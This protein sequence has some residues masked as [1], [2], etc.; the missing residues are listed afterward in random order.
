[1]TQ[2]DLFNIALAQSA[3]DLSCT[4][5]DLVSEILSAAV[6][7]SQPLGRPILGT[8]G[9]LQ[10]IDSQALS[11]YCRKQ[12]VGKNTIISLCGSFSEADLKA[13]E[14]IYTTA[15]KPGEDIVNM[16]DVMKGMDELKLD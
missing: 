4:P 2:K 10:A 7:P 3:I 9:T 8:Q 11:D 5:E 15:W 1:M 12:Y 6:Y 13:A 14:E 16:G